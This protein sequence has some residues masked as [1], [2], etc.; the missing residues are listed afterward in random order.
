MTIQEDLTLDKILKNIKIEEGISPEELSSMIKST[1]EKTKIPNYKAHNNFEAYTLAN[2]YGTPLI[3]T[4]NQLLDIYNTYL[5]SKN[6]PMVKTPNLNLK[7]SYIF[8]PGSNKSSEIFLINLDK[9]SV[10]LAEKIEKENKFFESLAYYYKFLKPE[11]SGDVE[12]YL[13]RIKKYHEA[14]GFKTQYSITTEKVP[15]FCFY[16]VH[17]L[18]SG[19]K[20]VKSLEGLDINLSRFFL[21]KDGEKQSKVYI[22][23]DGLILRTE[24]LVKGNEFLEKV[25]DYKRNLDEIDEMFVN[26]RK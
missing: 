4:Q 14:K 10:F 15:I 26:L 13:K 25:E 12:N 19:K 3:T 23:K 1:G 20:E 18:E 22:I 17:N 8:F 7:L 2:M 16:N 11:E 5:L 6:K 21:E 9:G 24:N